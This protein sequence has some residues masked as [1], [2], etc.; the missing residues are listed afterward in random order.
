MTMTMMMMMMMKIMIMI[1]IKITT[2]IAF[3]SFITKPITTLI[4]IM[5][6]L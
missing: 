3:P 2:M 6:I 4:T 5:V 1:T